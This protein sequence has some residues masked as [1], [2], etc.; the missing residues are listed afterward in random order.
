MRV[1]YRIPSLTPPLSAYRQGKP[2]GRY[3]Q[4]HYICH[5]VPRDRTAVLAVAVVVVNAQADAQGARDTGLRPNGGIRQGKEGSGLL[6][7]T[8]KQATPIE[9]IE[10]WHNTRAGA[11][12]E[13]THTPRRQAGYQHRPPP[14]HTPQARHARA[15]CFLENSNGI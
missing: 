9:A 3:A 12:A 11:T 10:Q 7:K 15:F 14:T 13:R 2:P 4:G 8:G 1:F 6:S 5:C